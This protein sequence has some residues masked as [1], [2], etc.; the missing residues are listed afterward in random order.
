MSRHVMTFH[1][2]IRLL[3]WVVSMAFI[4]LFTLW[5][6]IQAIQVVALVAVPR[7]ITHVRKTSADMRKFAYLKQQTLEYEMPDASRFD[8][9]LPSVPGQEPANPIGGGVRF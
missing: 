3:T 9:P 1:T 2:F 5:G 6:C 7:I 4:V 8:S